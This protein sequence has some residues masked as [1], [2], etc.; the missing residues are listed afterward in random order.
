[1]VP[2]GT[3][4]SPV[5]IQALDHYNDLINTALAHGITPVITILHYDLPTSVPYSDPNFSDPYLYYTKQIMTRYGDC[6][7]YWVSVNE[8]NLEPV[9]NA[10]TN[11]LIAH[12]NLYNWYK[13]ELQG[14]GKITITFANNLAIP[15]TDSPADVAAAL[16]Y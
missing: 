9:N 16:R 14:T 1:M 15:F 6:V 7:P 10:L 12:A 13:N 3:A 11:I 8:R 4:G 2:F 5:N